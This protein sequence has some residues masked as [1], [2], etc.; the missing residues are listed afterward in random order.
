MHL[1]VKHVMVLSPP[2]FCAYNSIL[3]NKIKCYLDKPKI[4]SQH[5]NVGIDTDI[6]CHYN[7]F[8]FIFTLTFD[9]VQ[10]SIKHSLNNFAILRFLYLNIQQFL[11]CIFLLNLYTVC[12]I[13]KMTSSSQ[14]S[15]RIVL[16]LKIV[17]YS[18]ESLFNLNLHLVRS[19]HLCIDSFMPSKESLSSFP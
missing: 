18:K 13:N 2:P 6:S 10:I 14:N 8:F 12:S 17:L 16:C 7:F 9:I 11:C 4:L 15:I 19:T 5:N 3:C 1:S